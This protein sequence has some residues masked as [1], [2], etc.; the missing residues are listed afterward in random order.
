[1]REL[2]EEK[3][4]RRNFEKASLVLLFLSLVLLAVVAGGALRYGSVASQRD[5]EQA[6]AQSN[7]TAA[8]SLASRVKRV[9]ASGGQESVRL[10]RSGLC[11][12]AV[13]VERNIRGVPG[14][15]G[16]RGPAGPAGV[17]GRDGVNGSAGLVG[18][19]GPQGSP[20]LNGVKGPDGLPG[21]NGS[22]GHDGVPGP[23]GPQGAQGERGERGP[24]GVNG[25]DGKD[26][27]NGR[28]VV[29]V[30][31]SD[32]RLVVKY[33][34][35]VASTISGSVACQGVKPSPIVTISSHK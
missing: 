27:K 7:G 30:Y 23:A 21:V 3:R 13:R 34:D 20:G 6:R 31:C 17:D 16:E 2:E 25:S 4:Q 24:A 18:P 12:D 35:G 14:P 22:D 33:S 1:M 28:S 19:V 29:S 11:V 32:G 9:C 15:A 10:H 26:G 8:R 5:S